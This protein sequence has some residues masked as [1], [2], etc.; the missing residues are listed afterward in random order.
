MHR[1]FCTSAKVNLFFLGCFVAKWNQ[2]VLTH[3]FTPAC[4]S[5]K[6]NSELDSAKGSKDN[7]G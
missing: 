4:F 7:M 6:L 5:E 2:N 3:Y 1:K